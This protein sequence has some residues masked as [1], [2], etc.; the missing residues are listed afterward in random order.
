MRLEKPNAVLAL[1]GAA[2]VGAVNGAVALL[3]PD[4]ANE[5]LPS[6]W[7]YLLAA[8]LLLIALSLRNALKGV[9]ATLWVTWF[10][11]GSLNALASATVLRSYYSNL[12]LHSAATIYLSAASLFILGLV[13]APESKGAVNLI[14]QDIGFV[15][16]AVLLGFPLLWFLSLYFSLGYVPL[17]SGA[18]ITEEIYALKY[19]PLYPYS[20]ILCL[21]ALHV[22]DRAIESQG[23]ARIW[24]SAYY[25][26]ILL[27][28]L[29]DGKRAI[30]LLSFFSSLPLLFHK[31][32]PKSAFHLGAGGSVAAIAIYA[33]AFVLRGGGEFDRYTV[34]IASAF[35]LVG[36]EYRD[37][38]YSVVHFNPGE[39]AGYSFLTSA[40]GS[41][42]NSSLLSLL[43]IDKTEVVSGGS[44]YVWS[45]LFA[46]PYGIRTGI[47]SELWFAY[48]EFAWPLF[49]LMGIAVG[50][51]I[52][53]SRRA[54][55][56]S[57][58]LFYFFLYGSACLSIFGQATAIFGSITVALY[59]LI[60]VNIEWWIGA[61]PTAS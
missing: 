25:L 36:V 33:G 16:R 3:F 60:F 7:H 22:L 23:A 4:F 28:S 26:T 42:M 50:W 6:V 40:L 37:F 46:S 32:G 12:D 35:L 18:D 14:R 27:V 8:A 49:V 39:I 5:L 45:G 2:G 9:I 13:F 38:A 52:Q 47:V 41:M 24:F 1:I 55:W 29:A 59:F 51:V 44:A 56:E 19:G 34:D 57:S 21:S 11:V 10:L 30:M 58:R 53:R 20:V 54:K 31:I 61:R 43:G 48:G 15:S 17:L